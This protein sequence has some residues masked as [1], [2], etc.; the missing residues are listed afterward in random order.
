MASAVTAGKLQ[1]TSINTGTR[2]GVGGSEAEAEECYRGIQQTNERLHQ[3]LAHQKINVKN[4]K[5]SVTMN[6]QIC[7]ILFSS[8]FLSLFLNEME[9][10][11]H[12]TGANDGF[13][14]VVR[15]ALFKI[16]CLT[17]SM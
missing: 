16:K 1:D 3:M 9:N 2:R 17:V 8:S 15:L 12:I 4:I 5:S 13:I 14:S 10:I 7:L 11:T 6:N